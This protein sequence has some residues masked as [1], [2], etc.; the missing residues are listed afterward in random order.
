MSGDA[1]GAADRKTGI[2]PMLSVRRGARAIE[3]YQ[4]AFGAGVLFRIDSEDGGVVARLAVGRPN[5][6]WPTNRR[7]TQISARSRWAVV[8]CGW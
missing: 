6:G 2:A 7:K 5:S 8:R 4:A 3:F 1:E